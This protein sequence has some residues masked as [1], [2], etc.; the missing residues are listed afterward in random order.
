M[1]TSW[2]LHNHTTGREIPNLGYITSSGIF[3]GAVKRRKWFVPHANSNNFIFIFINNMH[4]LFRVLVLGKSKITIVADLVWWQPLLKAVILTLQFRIR[5]SL[6]GVFSRICRNS[7]VSSANEIEHLRKTQRG[8]R[9]ETKITSTNYFHLNQ[10]TFG[11]ICD[12]SRSS[13]FQ[14]PLL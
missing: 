8:R 4:L 6:L 13:A 5:L 11:Q 10:V 2:L 3:T 12:R 14:G 9:N 7:C 1:L